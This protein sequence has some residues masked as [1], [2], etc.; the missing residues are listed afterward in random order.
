MALSSW[1]SQVGYMS[2]LPPE[3]RLDTRHFLL[4]PVQHALLFLGDLQQRSVFGKPVI[5]QILL[6]HQGRRV[7]YN[8]WL[9]RFEKESVDV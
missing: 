6:E 5:L 8:L 9:Q 2:L 3:F 1:L 4:L 7:T